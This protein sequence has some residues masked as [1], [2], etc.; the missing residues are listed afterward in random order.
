MKKLPLIASCVLI[1]AF[2]S[3]RLSAAGDQF[4]SVKD[5]GAVGNGVAQS[6]RKQYKPRLHR[7]IQHP[8]PGHSFFRQEHTSS[9]ISN[10][11]EPTT[12]ACRSMER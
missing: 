1:L 4:V 10:S 9:T 2:T 3:S 7:L 11:T 5:F 6:T 8:T 12:F